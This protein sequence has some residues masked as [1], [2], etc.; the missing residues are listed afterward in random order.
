M[1]ISDNGELI[2][3]APGVKTFGEDEQIDKL[4]R[5]FGYIGTETILEQMNDNDEL[6]DNAGAVAHMVHGSSEGRFN[7]TH[8]SWCLTK[9]EIES[10]GHECDDLDE[11]SECYNV[12]KM[13]DG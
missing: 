4:I 5:K 2:I 3:I 7:I 8:C 11:V 1:E 6:K 12:N 9:D 10:I 13:K